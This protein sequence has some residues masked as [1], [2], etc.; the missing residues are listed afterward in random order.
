[1]FNLCVST[2]VLRMDNF[3]YAMLNADVPV[4]YIGVSVDIHVKCVIKHSEK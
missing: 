2:S 4:I 3:T 1:M